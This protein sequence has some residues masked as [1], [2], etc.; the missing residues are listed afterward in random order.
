MVGASK[1]LY[2]LEKNSNGTRAKLV[3]CS[4][5]TMSDARFDSYGLICDS[6]S[7]KSPSMSVSPG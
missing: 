3:L 2:L 5:N 1:I 4:Y 6:G 7:E